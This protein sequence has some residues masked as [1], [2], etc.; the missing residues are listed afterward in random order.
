MSKTIEIWGGGNGSW[1][2]VDGDGDGGRG[3]DAMML[4]LLR[5]IFSRSQ[6]LKPAVGVAH[7]ISRQPAQ[8]KNLRIDFMSTSPLH[9]FIT[10]QPSWP[11]R[12]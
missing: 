5:N 8:P 9:R 7:V 6:G 3:G 4:M 12:V 1:I 11:P 2:F 10:L